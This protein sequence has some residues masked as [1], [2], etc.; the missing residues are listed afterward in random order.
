MPPKQQLKNSS[1][2]ATLKR[3]HTLGRHATPM[4]PDPPANPNHLAKLS[5]E[6]NMLSTQNE[7][8]HDSL[9]EVQD[10]LASFEDK[11]TD[12]L[13]QAQSLT[14]R[15]Q[16]NISRNGTSHSLPIEL[17]HNHFPWLETPTID[18][19]INRT[20]EVSHLIKLISLE[21]RS[22]VQITPPRINFDLE[23][24]KPTITTELNV[25]YEKHFLN[26]TS[27]NSALAVY[28]AVQSISDI[29]NTGIGFV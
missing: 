12:F 26:F 15:G 27:L 23:S 7:S 18:N 5:E 22:K 28:C 10:H 1:S 8:L 2:P 16:L 6:I 14:P 17:I 4:D 9:S 29:D 11:F 13:E 3:P 20:L 21:E 24:G 25:A 19:I